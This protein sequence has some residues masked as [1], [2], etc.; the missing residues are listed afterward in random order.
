M[1]TWNSRGLPDAESGTGA[2]N[3][4]ADQTDQY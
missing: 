4:D 2:E 3:P 1:P